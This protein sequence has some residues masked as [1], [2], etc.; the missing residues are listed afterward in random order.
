MHSFWHVPGRKVC[1]MIPQWVLLYFFSSCFDWWFDW[2]V[3]FGVLL[4]FVS[5]FQFCL[6][7]LCS[8]FVSFQSDINF[9]W[10]NFN[11]LLGCG[12]QYGCSFPFKRGT[13]IFSFSLFLLLWMVTFIFLIQFMMLESTIVLYAWKAGKKT[14]DQICGLYMELCRKKHWSCTDIWQ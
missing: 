2:P 14:I 7:V 5:N 12:A 8:L 4:F 13:L 6:L 11:Y 1:S 9:Y 3:S 10:S